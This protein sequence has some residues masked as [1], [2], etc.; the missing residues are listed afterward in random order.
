MCLEQWQ[1]QDFLEEEAPNVKVGRQPIIFPN[2]PQKF[3]ENETKM[4]GG[5]GVC[6]WRPHESANGEGAVWFRHSS[7]RYFTKMHGMCNETY[8]YSGGE[9][10]CPNP[11]SSRSD[12]QY[13]YQ[14]L[15]EFLQ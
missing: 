7:I 11:C 15:D 13:V 14:R 2:C 5:G 12:V 8:L 4:S 1:I 9:A 6:P 10:Q 3:H